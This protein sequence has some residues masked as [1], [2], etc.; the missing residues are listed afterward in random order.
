[1]TLDMENNK[2]KDMDLPIIKNFI[3]KSKIIITDGLFT[4]I[5]FIVSSF[6]GDYKLNVDGEKVTENILVNH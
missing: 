5:I 4:L 1:M 6:G 3:A 2:S